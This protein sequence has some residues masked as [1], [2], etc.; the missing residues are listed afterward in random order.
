[1]NNI[2]YYLLALLAGVALATQTG[3]NAQLRS[4]VGSPVLA[5][6]ISFL[7]GTVAL[8]LYVT[9]F[10]R[11]SYGAI[12]QMKGMAFYK[13]LGG[14]IGAAYVCSVIVLAPRI[15][16]ANLLALIVGGQILFALFLDHFG[17]LGFQ[18]HSFNVFRLAGACLLIGGVVLI[19]KN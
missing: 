6:L 18:Q 1:M 8:V 12:H 11:E 19:L 5:T 4:V 2:A 16:A 14:L 3:I 10:E 13:I 17:L 9:L 15:G 7:V